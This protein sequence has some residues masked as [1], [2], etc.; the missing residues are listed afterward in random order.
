[1]ADTALSPCSDPFKEYLTEIGAT[2]VPA[3][4]KQRTL[5]YEGGSLYFVPWGHDK[6]PLVCSILYVDPVGF[7]EFIRGSVKGPMFVVKVLL[8]A[9]NE[10]I[11]RWTAAAEKIAKYSDK[12]RVYEESPF[13]MPLT[14]DMYSD[15]DW[16]MSDDLTFN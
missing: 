1:M 5:P 4:T 2:V 12:E 8:P 13:I 7:D 3:H 11:R 14:L 10:S 16:F 9:P 6:T 15:P